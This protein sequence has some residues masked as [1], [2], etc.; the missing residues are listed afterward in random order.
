M[1]PSV[2]SVR[3]TS[4]EHPTSG[5]AGSNLTIDTVVLPLPNLTP[6]PAEKEEADTSANGAVVGASTLSATTQPFMPSTYTPEAASAAINDWTSNIAAFLAKTKAGT[7]AAALATEEEPDFSAPNQ[8]REARHVAAAAMA[9]AA[10]PTRPRGANQWSEI[11]ALVEGVSLWR[12][13]DTPS[14]SRLTQHESSQAYIANTLAAA[15]NIKR[16]DYVDHGLHEA[17]SALKLDGEASEDA[18]RAREAVYNSTQT[19]LAKALE[20]CA[21][22]SLP[23]KGVPTSAKVDTALSEWF[24]QLTLEAPA[25]PH[26]EEARFLDRVTMQT[27]VR[28]AIAAMATDK[29]AQIVEE[30][31]KAAAIA[32]EKKI[33]ALVANHREAVWKAHAEAQAA[34]Q[35]HAKRE[36]EEERAAAARAQLRAAQQAAQEKE[37][38]IRSTLTD[39]KRRRAARIRRITLA[40]VTD[41]REDRRSLSFPCS[42]HL[43]SLWRRGKLA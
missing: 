28:E 39:V 2:V 35:A 42:Q 31:Q 10:A 25:D 21:T 6:L 22:G 18:R 37:L 3:T 5:L 12:L 30:E 27:S 1:D 13:D 38:A 32:R 43:R 33:T 23:S 24:G 15:E 16:L 4:P 40:A 14:P 36:K 8:L 17:M 20:M 34:Q 29:R 19:H 26:E 9:A 7:E 41:A 11:D